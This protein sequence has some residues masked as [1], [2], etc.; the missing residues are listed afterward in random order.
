MYVALIIL[1]IIAAVLLTFLVVRP[2]LNRIEWGRSAKGWDKLLN[3]PGTDE[4]FRNSF[5]VSNISYAIAKVLRPSRA[6]YFKFM[7][8]LYYLAFE[9]D[10]I[11]IDM[12]R[13]AHFFSFYTRSIRS[14]A[15]QIERP[16]GLSMFFIAA[17]PDV[18]DLI[19][20]EGFEESALLYEGI[21]EDQLSLALDK[22][23]DSAE[24]IDVYAMMI[25][26]YVAKVKPTLEIQWP[27]E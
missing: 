4:A 18:V 17:F 21:P 8:N 6:D 9:G 13:D 22:G 23:N 25:E 19:N 24:R 3:H 16:V 11:R 14:F 15:S 10:Q 27:V 1:G 20:G 12:N 7:S 26:N 5:H 2:M